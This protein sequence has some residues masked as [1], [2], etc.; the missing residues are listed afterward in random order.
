VAV[1]ALA[2]L[3]SAVVDWE[4]APVRA[5]RVPSRA[6]G[7]GYVR[8]HVTLHAMPKS[9]DEWVQAMDEAD[10]LEPPLAAPAACSRCL[11]PLEVSK[12]QWGT[13]Y[14]CGHEH[15]QTLPRITAVTYGAAGTR[16]WSFFTTTK[17]GDVEDTK[18]KSFVKGIAAMLSRAIE[19]SHPDFTKGDAAYVVVAVPSS[20]GLIKRCLDVIAT[21]GWSS[22]I[23]VDAL[24][25]ETR[26]KQT[27]LG[28]D[29]RREAASGKYTASDGVS[30]KHVLL[31]D[32]AYT[33]GYTI[34]DAARAVSAAG[35]LSVSCVV[36]ARR[37]YPEA[38][39]I[40][41][42]ETGEDDDENR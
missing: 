38:R 29:K 36:Y 32:D 13:C 15:P 19:T 11:R 23:A 40:Y 1:G 42:A 31:L 10:V 21:K 27:G 37:I 26:P 25:A 12:R 17:F 4:L 7:V 41:R 5:R 22:L 2:D 18:I 28:E 16:P 39:A 34:H 9:R 14:R 3:A 20:S 30:G 24:T 33:S 8:Y 6:P 35:A